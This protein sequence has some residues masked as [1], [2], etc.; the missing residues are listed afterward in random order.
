MSA[1]SAANRVAL[2][3]FCVWLAIAYAAADHPPPPSFLFLVLALLLCA[4]FVRLRVPTYLAWHA[5]R[6][7]GRIGRVICE[8]AVG[9]GVLYLVLL[10]LSSGEPS[11]QPDIGARLIGAGVMVVLGATNAL[12]V[13][14]SGVTL[15]LWTGGLAWRPL[16]SNRIRERC[17]SGR[18]PSVRRDD[19][20]QL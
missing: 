2:I 5:Q 1:A 16:R 6:S 3:F 9:G 20:C 11:I 18:D 13:Y 17:I 12:M 14:G 19:D 15:S 4:L 7:R 8:G 10:V